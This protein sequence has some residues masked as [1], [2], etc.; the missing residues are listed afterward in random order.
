MKVSAIMPAYNEED[1]IAECISSLLNQTMDSMEII[2]IDDGSTDKTPK[3]IQ[4][5]AK[6]NKNLRFIQQ[7]HKGAATGWNNGLKHAKGK[8]ILIVGADMV[9]GKNYVKDICT[10]ILNK[11]TESSMYKEAKIAN[12]KNLWA[13]AR[14]KSIK[15]SETAFVGIDKKEL[16]SIGG[17]DT[18]I[19]YADDELL[20][21]KKGLKP[22]MI[23]TEI[24]HYNPSSLKESYGQFLW[25]GSSIKT[26]YLIAFLFPLAPILGTLKAITHFIKDPYL[27][28][29]IFLPWY[30]TVKYF[31]YGIGAWK[32]IL[33]K[34]NIK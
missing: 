2:I 8:V 23:E 10:P 7:N 24:A 11:K 34:K 19:G 17:F 25:I 1:T 20:Y 33:F 9:M 30:H 22:M 31:G 13:R 26:R 14:G 5:Y 4:S 32:W 16:L 21:R 29:I 6:K 27:P 12:I 15:G 28:F 3:I 18:S